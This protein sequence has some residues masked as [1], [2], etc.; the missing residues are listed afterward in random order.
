LDEIG[1]SAVSTTQRLFSPCQQPLLPLLDGG[2]PQLATDL[3]A[4]YGDCICDEVN[5]HAAHL[6]HKLEYW[7]QLEMALCAIKRGT[8]KSNNHV[9]GKELLFAHCQARD[10][11]FLFLE[12]KEKREFISSMMAMRPKLNG[13]KKQSTV[14]SEF[15]I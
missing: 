9:L 12:G 7:K 15:C 1:L 11:A 10:M 2:C 4:N 13:A 14:D 5:H 3:I 6:A 8:T